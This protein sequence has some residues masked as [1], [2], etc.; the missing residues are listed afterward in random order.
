MSTDRESFR[1]AV[2]DSGVAATH[3]HL[4]GVAIGGFSVDEDGAISRDFRDHHG[5]GTAVAAAIFE[6][7]DQGRLLA[8]RVLDP[9]LRC[10][11]AALAHGIAL[12]A[13]HGARVINVSMGTRAQD[14]AEPL[15]EAVARAKVA[16]A[17]VVAAAPPTGAAWPADLA[18]VVG[19]EVDPDCPPGSHRTIVRPLQ[20]PDGCDRDVLRFATHGRARHADGLV[21]NFAGHSLAAAHMTAIA[22]KSLAAHP[23]PD[24]VELVRRLKRCGLRRSA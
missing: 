4:D 12:A 11:H 5:H 9:D 14:G 3:P 10:S 22:A 6:G 15:R 23:T 2:V 18:D 7:I 8:V 13:E 19:V 24:V 17:V 20:L 1:I 21:D 16:G